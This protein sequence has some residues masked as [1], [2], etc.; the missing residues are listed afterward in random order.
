M[1]TMDRTRELK[2]FLPEPDDNVII[3]RCEEITKGE[4]RKAVHDGMWTMNELKR[5]TR[6][7][8]GLCQGQTCEL[9]V[10]RIVAKE[11]GIPA[12]DLEEI[13]ARM[14]NRPVEIAIYEEGMAKYEK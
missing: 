7:C 5:Y 12:S 1:K 13:T 14:P 6:A 4:I 11:L 3:C 8:M 2:P 10:R 9:N